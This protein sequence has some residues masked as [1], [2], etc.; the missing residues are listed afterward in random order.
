[1]STAVH[2]LR[3]DVQPLTGRFTHTKAGL[4]GKQ[5]HLDLSAARH[6]PAVKGLRMRSTARDLIATTAVTDAGVPQPG[7]SSAIFLKG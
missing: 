1:L 2:P 5:L 7:G 4:G 6:W 3:S